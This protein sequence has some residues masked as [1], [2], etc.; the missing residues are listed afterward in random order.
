ATMTSLLVID[1]LHTEIRLRRSV[2]HA[3][4]GVSLTVDSG[5]CL[6]IV[7]ESGSGKTVTALSI[8]RL[9]PS[10]GHITGGRIIVD[11]VNIAALP[12]E[13]MQ[14]VRGNLVGMVFQDPLT[15]LNPTMTIGD[16][17]AE[18]VR[19]HRG[20]SKQAALAHAV[21][22]LGLVGMPLP[23]ERVT[24]Y[25]HQLSGGM[26]QRVMIAMALACEP[27]VADRR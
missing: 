27:K 14:D 25:P 4:D 23:A 15:S 2:V 24:N 10:G 11:G 12:E 1:G 17:I 26:R 18:S 9:L 16:Q 20:A 13:K 22:V 7:G 3:I 5:E 8:M 6:G 21:E 19:L